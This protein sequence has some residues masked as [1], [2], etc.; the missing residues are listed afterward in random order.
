MYSYNN[1]KKGTDCAA[2]F[3]AYALVI[4]FWGGLLFFLLWILNHFINLRQIFQ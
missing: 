2:I 3:V 4:A 1:N